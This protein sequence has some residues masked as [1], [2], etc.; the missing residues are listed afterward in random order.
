MMLMESQVISRASEQNSNAA[1]SITSEV[2]GE[3]L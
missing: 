1:I 2:N 3:L